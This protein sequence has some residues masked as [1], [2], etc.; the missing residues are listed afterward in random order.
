MTLNLH[1]E[2]QKTWAWNVGMDR[3]VDWSTEK[4]H[5]ESV[6][7]IML[8]CILDILQLGSNKKV[9]HLQSVCSFFLR[10]DS[11]WAEMVS[12]RW[13]VRETKSLVHA[14]C[15]HPWTSTKCSNNNI[16]KWMKHNFNDFFGWTIFD[17]KIPGLHLPSFF[18]KVHQLSP[19]G[20]F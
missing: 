11:R 6:E 4:W 16:D 13:S 1:V 20:A 2:E 8:H 10:P 7:L 3:T 14:F 19:A 9:V 12:R 17:G 5:V 15:F 18:K